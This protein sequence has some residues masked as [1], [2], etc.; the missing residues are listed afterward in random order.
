MKSISEAPDAIVLV[1]RGAPGWRVEGCRS[2]LFVCAEMFLDLR[3]IESRR[4][5]MWSLRAGLV[6]AGLRVAA[7]SDFLLAEDIDWIESQSARTAHQWYMG[8]EGDETMYRGVSLGRCVEYQVKARAVRLFKLSRCLQRLLERYPDAKVYSD[9]DEESTEQRVL[10]KAHAAIFRFGTS[11]E[12][13]V[14]C[15]PRGEAR[16]PLAASIVA[17]GRQW[18][19][20]GVGLLADAVQTLRRSDAPVVVVRL[21][22]QTLKML[23]AWMTSHKR[24]QVRF[25]LWM[26]HLV[27]PREVVALVAAGSLVVQRVPVVS[28]ESMRG[29]STLDKQVAR[30]FCGEPGPRL[31][32]VFRDLLQEIAHNAFPVARSAI[33]HAYETFEQTQSRLL[34]APNDCLLV[35]R[36][37]TLVAQCSG[38]SSLVVQHGH[39]DYTEDENH[40][41][42]THSAFWSDMVVRQFQDAGLRP[43]QTIMTGSPTADRYGQ[44]ANGRRGPRRRPRILIATT[45]NP[46]VQAYID[47]SWV[48]DYIAGVLDALA[49]CSNDFS[50]TLRLHPGESSRLYRHHLGAKLPSDTTMSDRGDI[51]RVLSE[52][53]LM[54]SPP[55]TVVLEARAIGLPVI[56]LRVP[57]AN[58]RQTTLEQVDGVVTAGGYDELPAIVSTVL[59]GQ[60]LPRTG[61]VPLPAFLGPLDGQSSRRL[62]DAV[63]GLAHL[64]HAFAPASRTE[65]EFG[66]DV[67]H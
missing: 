36:A 59:A 19:L 47:E 11:E 34:V 8:S 20:W 56:L 60:V 15:R 37:W 44:L 10:R 55:S 22:P 53:D 7:L 6:S 4:W 61:T 28:S 24:T 64:P 40:L 66:S 54:I 50:I 33:D 57:S 51:A 39:L 62:F 9:F 67:R 35:S 27:R 46:G 49:L 29:L 17:K 58:D 13:A 48:C 41:T 5:Q 16:Q 32:S 38:M 65:L 12:R 3:D 14:V 42:A 18:G 63:A 23:G 21:S 52:A 31:E 25:A 2:P 43:E 30:Q 45:G 26:D 1:H